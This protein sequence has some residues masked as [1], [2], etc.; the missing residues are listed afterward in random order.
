MT[1][2]RQA[3][4]LDRIGDPLVFRVIEL[5]CVLFRGVRDDGRPRSLPFIIV[6]VG[7]DPCFSEW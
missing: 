7:V 5:S 2:E 6:W 4:G 1:V 3:I